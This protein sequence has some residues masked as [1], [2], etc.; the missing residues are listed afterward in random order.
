M[1]HRFRPKSVGVL[2]ALLLTGAA[3]MAVIG[4]VAHAYYVSA[5]CL[6]L[7]ALLLRT[8][9]GLALFKTIL[10]AN[11]TSGLV[12]VLVLWLGDAMGDA[13]LDVTG[14]MLIANVLTGGPLM[15]V[16]GVAIIP[17]LREGHR[18]FAWFHSGRAALPARSVAGHAS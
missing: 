10:I 14:V 8:G 18:V 15:S 1:N 13:K 4:W 11:Q 6:G 7:Q 12:L 17:A 9:R 16:L 3:I 5:L 2:T